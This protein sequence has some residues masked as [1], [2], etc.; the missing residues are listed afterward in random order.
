MRLTTFTDYSLRVLIFLA[1]QPDR[2]TTIAEVADAFRISESHL[3]KVVHGLGKAG[4]LAN[5]RG[6]GGG[7]QL[8]KQARDINVGAVVRATEGAAMPAECFDAESNEC[9]ITRVCR[10]RGVL[11]EAV[12]AFY[13]VLDRYSLED[14][15]SNRQPLGR[16]LFTARERPVRR[17]VRR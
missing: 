12:R 16:I 3:T 11:A 7:L 4:F 5:V 17:A 14:L 13:A 9:A 10:L 6:H 15:V 8:A 2:R 1:V